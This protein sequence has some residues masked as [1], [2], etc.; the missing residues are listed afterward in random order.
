MSINLTKSDW[1]QVIENA[2]TYLVFLAMIVYGVGKYI[3]F[4]DTSS[5]SKAVNELDGM[6]LMW[7]FYGYS[8]PFAI[9]IGILEITGAVLLLIPKTRLIGCFFLTT[10]LANI[11]LQDI[12]YGVNVG[13]L[14]A[15]IIY[16]MCIIVILLINRK[17]VFE[18]FK[19][20]MRPLGLFNSSK[21]EIYVLS[22]ILFIAL[23]FIE[24]IL[25]H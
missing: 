2:L 18:S 16:Q 25:T 5:V 7:L 24:Y 17:R 13:A 19:K 20:I 22:V 10:I 12:F 1:L 6:E 15:A 23:R 11:I 8:K 9:L 3:Q 4:P 21:V 14:K